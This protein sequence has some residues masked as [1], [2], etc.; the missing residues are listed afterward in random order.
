MGSEIE[1]MKRNGDE[2]VRGMR[3]G[4]IRVH[5]LWFAK[6][7]QRDLGFESRERKWKYIKEKNGK[8]A[9]NYRGRNVLP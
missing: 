8:I 1:V 5:E 3:E 2:V 6:W 4:E 9:P 7:N